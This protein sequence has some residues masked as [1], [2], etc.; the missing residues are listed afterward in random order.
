MLEQ[1]VRRFPEFG[2]LLTPHVLR[3]TYND[4]FVETAR[5]TGIDG[6]APKAAQNYING[7]SLTSEQGALY[8]GRALQERARE[9]SLAHQ[10][11]LFS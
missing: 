5:T 7:W 2:G 9:L 11:R 3:Y 4:M 1:V 6:E 8:A 10:R